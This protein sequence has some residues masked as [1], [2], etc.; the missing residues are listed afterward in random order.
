MPDETNTPIANVIAISGSLREGSY[1]MAALRAAQRLRPKGMNIDL[2]HYADVPV[3][4]GDVEAAGLPEP[5]RRTQ[6]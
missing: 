4:N 2:L 1:N 5:V 6:F 3:Y